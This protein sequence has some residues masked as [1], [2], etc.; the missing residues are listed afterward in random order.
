MFTDVDFYLLCFCFNTSFVFRETCLFTPVS[1]KLRL[2]IQIHKS[3]ISLCE[4]GF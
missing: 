3:F 4:F 1:E 2:H